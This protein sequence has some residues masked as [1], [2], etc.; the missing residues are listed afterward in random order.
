[1]AVNTRLTKDMCPTTDSERD[2]MSKI[3]YREIVGVLLWCLTVCRPDLSYAVNQVAKFNSYPELA[4]W[5]ALH[6][7]LLYAYQSVE[8][9]IRFLGPKDDNIVYD[10]IINFE[11]WTDMLILV[12]ILIR[13]YQSQEI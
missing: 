10:P 6:R 12:L 2:F 3:P 13:P 9:G 1:M 4:N 11:S 5:E 7:F 8:W